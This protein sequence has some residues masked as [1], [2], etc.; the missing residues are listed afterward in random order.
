VVAM[1]G[2]ERKSDEKNRE[3][4]RRAELQPGENF[5]TVNYF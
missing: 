1:V 4:N 5:Q 2:Q 3:E